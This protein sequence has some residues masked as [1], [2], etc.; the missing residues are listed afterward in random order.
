MLLQCKMVKAKGVCV[1]NNCCQWLRMQKRQLENLLM[2]R[3]GLPFQWWTVLMVGSPVTGLFTTVMGVV[4]V[5]M[6]A[7]ELSVELLVVPGVLCW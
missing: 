6:A 2:S 4:V 5:A 1:K 7:D 3:H